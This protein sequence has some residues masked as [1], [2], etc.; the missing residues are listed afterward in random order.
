MTLLV[1]IREQVID[2]AI[3]GM[4][5]N[6]AQDRQLVN[7]TP[8]LDSLGE[9]LAAIGQSTREQGTRRLAVI[10]L[11]LVRDLRDLNDAEHGCEHRI[12]GQAGL[13]TEDMAATRRRWTIKRLAA[14]LRPLLSDLANPLV[15]GQAQEQRLARLAE[16][17]A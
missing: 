14:D 16:I 13:L 2:E 10:G 5:A 11:G 17:V 3:T 9:I 12:A 1:T 4:A 15:R 7:D 6:R 8:E